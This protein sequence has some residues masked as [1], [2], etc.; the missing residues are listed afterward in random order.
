MCR[1]HEVIATREV[2]RFRVLPTSTFAAQ[3]FATTSARASRGERSDEPAVRHQGD[4]PRAATSDAALIRTLLPHL[5][6]ALAIH[7]RF[8]ALAAESAAP[9]PQVLDR[10]PFGVVAARRARAFAARESPPSSAILASRGRP[11]PVARRSPRSAGRRPTGVVRA[12]RSPTPAR[13][14]AAGASDAGGT[15][16][17]SGRRADIRSRCWSTP[18]PGSQIS[19]SARPASRCR[20]SVRPRNEV[21]GSRARSC[22]NFMASRRRNPSLP[23]MLLAGKD[24]GRLRRARGLENTVRTHE[25]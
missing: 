12:L 15:L 19:A 3:A 2:E 8:E 14:E 22:S 10:L 11:F 16:S 18:L 17:C 21:R 20:H 25:A 9:S 6:R 23:W 7:R 5:Q 1:S 4:R 24:C 13:P